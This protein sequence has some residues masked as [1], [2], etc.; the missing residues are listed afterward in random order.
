MARSRPTPSVSRRTALAGLGAGGLGLALA[1]RAAAAQESTPADLAGH[2]LVGTWFLDNDPANPA[3]PPGTFI[4]HADGSYV[5]VNADGPVRL[6]AWEATGDTTATLTIVAYDQ[7]AAGAS[8]GGITIRLAIELDPGGDS[9]HA[10]GTIE[11]VAP[12]GSSRGQGGP[13]PCTTSPL[14]RDAPPI[15][16]GAIPGRTDRPRAPEHGAFIVSWRC[17][18]AGCR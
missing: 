1:A 5:E 13:V 15:D 2:P 17:G 11:L 18:R 9:Y 4:L 8:L 6:G 12:D 16:H 10:V 3:N 7:D 14:R